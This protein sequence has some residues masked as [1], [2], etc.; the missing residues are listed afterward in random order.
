MIHNK[1]G[2]KENY[3]YEFD[4]QSGYNDC[5]FKHLD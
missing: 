2:Y 1:E 4:P 3:I 5:T